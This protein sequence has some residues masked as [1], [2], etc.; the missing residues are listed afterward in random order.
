MYQYRPVTHSAHQLLL[1]ENREE[2]E[3]RN[4]E[5]IGEERRL[6]S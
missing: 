6:D 5:K 4:R 2:R 3:E 1:E